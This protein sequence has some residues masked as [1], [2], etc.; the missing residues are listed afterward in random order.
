[1]EGYAAGLLGG[2]REDGNETLEG[3]CVGHGQ[4]SLSLS[5]PRAHLIAHPFAKMPLKSAFWYTISA[6]RRL[7]ARA[8]PT[9]II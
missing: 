9:V 5:L 8:R 6:M 1:M 3:K 2:T 4:L 7:R